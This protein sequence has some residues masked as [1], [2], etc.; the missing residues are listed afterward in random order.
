MHPVHVRNTFSGTFDCYSEL[1]LNFEKVD[2]AICSDCV[3][4]MKRVVIAD[5]IELEIY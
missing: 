4:Q 1:V 2:A 5:K 3:G